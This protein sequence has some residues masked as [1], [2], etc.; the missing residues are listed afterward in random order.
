MPEV[1]VYVDQKTYIKFLKQL[2]KNEDYRKEIAKWIKEDL[3][4]LKYEGE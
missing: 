2:E 1:K 4:T 3:G